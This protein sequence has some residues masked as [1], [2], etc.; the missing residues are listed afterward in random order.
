MRKTTDSEKLYIWVILCIAVVFCVWLF[1]MATAY[2]RPMSNNECKAIAQ[3]MEVIA[4][5]R[6]SKVAIK[7]T[8]Q[9]VED[10]LRPHMGEEASYVQFETDI[11]F[12][13]DMVQ[14]IYDSKMTPT[15][16]AQSAYGVCREHGYGVGYKVQ[17]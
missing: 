15:A 6:D 13:V 14:V 7:T 10:G 16:I 9:F 8:E 12:M 2:A 3:D 5:M 1:A 17:M 4:Q 11:A